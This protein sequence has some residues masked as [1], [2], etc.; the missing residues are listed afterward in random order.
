MRLIRFSLDVNGVSF[1][2]AF[3]AIL[4]G[5][6]VLLNWIQSFSIRS[7]RFFSRCNQVSIRSYYIPSLIFR[8]HD[9]YSTPPNNT[10]VSEYVR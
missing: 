7:S 9:K 3:I 10:F 8:S 1:L 4:T 6:Y 2:I 5:F